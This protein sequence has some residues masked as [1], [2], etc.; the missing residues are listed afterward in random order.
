MMQYSSDY[1]EKFMP[2]RRSSATDGARVCGGQ[3][4]MTLQPYLKSL[5]V[6]KCPSD[7][8]TAG[9]GCTLAATQAFATGPN[10]NWTSNEKRSYCILAGHSSTLTI[11]GVEWQYAGGV[12][13][14][15]WGAPMS[16][17]TSPANIMCYERWENG[18]NLY[19]PSFVH[20]TLDTD[21]C[22]VQGFQTVMRKVAWFSFNPPLNEGTHA[23][24]ATLMFADGHAK[25]LRYEQT[26][27]GNVPAASQPGAVS[28]GGTAV[29]TTM[30]DKRRL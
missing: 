9:A 8:S 27:N 24:R 19:T 3:W 20:A 16:Q 23:S 25:Q 7:T 4:N 17:I 10:Q 21:W 14:P 11:T 12:A 1:D 29:T 6:F 22:M 5:Q 15:N 26:Y 2:T 13:G 18:N 28:C 30:W